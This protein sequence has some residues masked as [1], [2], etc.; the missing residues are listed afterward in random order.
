M[1]SAAI[2]DACETCTQPTHCRQASTRVAPTPQNKTLGLLQNAKKASASRK[3]LTEREVVPARR[4]VAAATMRVARE[5]AIV[6]ETMGVAK[7]EPARRGDDSLARRGFPGLRIAG[8]KTCPAWK[9]HLPAGTSSRSW[10]GML[11]HG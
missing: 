8:S 7:V 3:R 4:T 5:A 6:L 2:T 11:C 9:A 1:T 10:Q